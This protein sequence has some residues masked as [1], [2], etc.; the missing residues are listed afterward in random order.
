MTA[1]ESASKIAERRSRSERSASKVWRSAARIVSSARPRSEI[2]SRP[3]VPS[4]GRSS[5]PWLIFAAESASFLI[6]EVIALAIRNEIATAT[7]SATRSAVMRSPRTASIASWSSEGARARASTTPS[8]TPSRVT[9]VAT[10][11]VPPVSGSMKSCA[12][13]RG[14]DRPLPVLDVLDVEALGGRDR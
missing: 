12:V 5:W 11:V 2:S 14:R 6:R 9:G 8:M 4:S 10:T 3:P 7:T 13:E 1:S